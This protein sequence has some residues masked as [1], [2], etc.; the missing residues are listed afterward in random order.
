MVKFISLCFFDLLRSK[1]VDVE[2]TIEVP[3]QALEVLRRVHT[4]SREERVSADP[5]FFHKSTAFDGIEGYS[6]E[7]I[8]D[9]LRNDLIGLAGVVLYSNTP[10]VISEGDDRSVSIAGC[11]RYVDDDPHR[12]G[13][14]FEHSGIYVPPHVKAAIQRAEV[15]EDNSDYYNVSLG[16]NACA[17]P[18]LRYLVNVTDTF[19]R[20]GVE[21]Y[22]QLSMERLAESLTSGR[23]RDREFDLVR[24]LT[25]VVGEIIHPIGPDRFMK[26]LFLP[27][28]NIARAEL[29]LSQSSA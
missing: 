23:L 3:R 26:T 27:P 4:P 10:L 25:G 6:A 22:P 18:A 24:S 21:N 1:M 15:D 14:V 8:Q 9:F 13:R 11:N 16:F 5:A 2:Y 19:F 29:I 7:E 20:K 17:L 12:G 28:H